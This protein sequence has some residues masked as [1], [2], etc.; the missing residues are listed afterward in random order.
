MSDRPPP[1]GPWQ[2]GPQ[3][4]GGQPGQA[5][6]GPPSYPPPAPG[7]PP[8]PAPGQGPAGPPPGAPAPGHYAP[9]TPGHPPQAPQGPGYPPQAPQGPGSPQGYGPQGPGGP[10]GYGPQGPG[11][12]PPGSPSAKKGKGGLIAALLVLLVLVIAAVAVVA[13]G[14]LGGSAGAGDTVAALATDEVEAV[15]LR[16]AVANAVREGSQEDLQEAIDE[17]DD[18]FADATSITTDDPETVPLDTTGLAALTFDAEAGDGFTLVSSL[19]DDDGVELEHAVIAPDGSARTPAA[20][21]AADAA[22]AHTVLVVAPAD[23]EGDV[24]V[25]VR[26][27]EVVQIELSGGDIT[28]EEAELADDGDAVDFEVGL[29][30]GQQYGLFVTDDWDDGDVTVEAV[31]PDGGAVE[32]FVVSDEEAYPGANLYADD[33]AFTAETSG[34][35]RIRIS[36]APPEGTSFDLTISRVPEFEFFYDS[37]NDDLSISPTTAQFSPLVN[38]ADNRA[39]FCLFLRSGVSMDVEAAPDDPGL[40]MGI[41]I[42]DET[43]SGPLVARINEFGPGQ[44]ENWS[45][46]ADRNTTRC[47][48]L[49]GVDFTGGGF[50]VSFTTE[51]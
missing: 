26:P 23:T 27:I 19:E 30:A 33:A 38:S 2:P 46:T 47:F 28:T 21:I 51:T 31:D 11:G 32:T 17:G 35:H 37:D 18:L 34:A 15:E 39:H 6:V 48:Q 36:G 20:S 14:V 8:Q 44:A 12:P 24:V 40:D 9:P 1:Q 10:P 49:W 29:E 43:E 25:A 42:F 7:P 13:T 5:P 50:T 22:G 16:E 45:V 4:P 41:D 3:P